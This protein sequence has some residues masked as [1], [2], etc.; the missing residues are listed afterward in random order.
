MLLPLL[1]MMMIRVMGLVVEVVLEGLVG[2]P[3]AAAVGTVSSIT[4]ADAIVAAHH[5]LLLGA[6]LL[7][8]LHPLLYAP[9]PT[10]ARA[11][12]RAGAAVAPNRAGGGPPRGQ[13]RGSRRS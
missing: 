9:H 10:G 4:A 6:R 3:A 8:P 11:G 5:L 2:L 13:R 12:T 1:L 7:L